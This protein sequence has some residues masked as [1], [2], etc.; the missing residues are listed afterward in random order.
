MSELETAPYE[1]GGGEDFGEGDPHIMVKDDGL[2]YNSG[3]SSEEDHRV[4]R[5]KRRGG[6]SAE[7]WRGR[8][9]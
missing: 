7:S 3:Q 1:E 6:L 5:G 4:S 8:G 9:R 2:V